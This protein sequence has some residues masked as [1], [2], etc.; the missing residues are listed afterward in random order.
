[1]ETVGGEQEK[2]RAKVA[3]VDDCPSARTMALTVSNRIKHRAKVVFGSGDTL[4]ATTLTANEGFVRA[5]AHKVHFCSELY[6]LFNQPIMFIGTFYIRNED[7]SLM[8]S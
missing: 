1:V 7:T 8:L 2:T 6:L 3:V 4:C 5:A